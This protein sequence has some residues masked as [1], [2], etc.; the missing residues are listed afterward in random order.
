MAHLVFASFGLSWLVSAS[1]AGD[2]CSPMQTEGQAGCSSGTGMGA[3]LI[4]RQLQGSKQVLA[5]EVGTDSKTGE[6]SLG[7][8]LNFL[9]A[10]AEKSEGHDWTMTDDEKMAIETI[11][12]MIAD[13]F[14]GSLIQFAEDQQEVIRARRRINQCSHD[15]DERH[16]TTV[17]PERQEANRARVDHAQCRIRENNMIANTSRW[18]TSYHNYRKNEDNFD[19]FPDCMA[20]ALTWNNIKT[21]EHVKKHAME[22]CLVLTV[23]TLLPLYKEL[24]ACRRANGHRIDVGAECD[25]KQTKFEEDFCDYAHHLHSK[26]HARSICVR[27][28]IAE[29]NVTHDW[30]RK[31]EIARKAD[32]KTATHIECLLQ[33][34]ERDNANK[35]AQ[36]NECAWAEVDTSNITIHYPRIPPIPPCPVE[37]STPCDQ[38][39][40]ETEYR[41]QEWYN[42]STIDTCTP[43]LESLTCLSEQACASAAEAMGLELG[44]VGHDFAGDFHTKGCYSYSS[45]S[46]YE[47]HA[48]F[49]TGGTAADM[50]AEPSGA[51][52]RIVCTQP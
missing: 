30:V 28:K 32:W 16:N 29:R 9:T 7:H 12:E 49:G 31:A 6:N 21:D 22:A 17:I 34:F 42:S 39:W 38:A 43:C 14:N 45:G 25:R 50:A 10:L 5:D 11:K 51:Q 2:L 24:L 44:G 46:D 41:S 52:F 8:A 40:L 3:A 47:G 15:A 27:D 33:V 1:A 35:T 37:E 19:P 23:E 20:T 36:L 4:Q 48:Y 13:L 18:C 26:C